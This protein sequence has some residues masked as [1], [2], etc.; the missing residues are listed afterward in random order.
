[1]KHAELNTHMHTAEWER[2]KL[3]EPKHRCVLSILNPGLNILS[4]YSFAK[5]YHWGRLGKGHAESLCVI[6]FYKNRLIEI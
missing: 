4:Y 3:G 2:L 6:C 1:M 5:Y